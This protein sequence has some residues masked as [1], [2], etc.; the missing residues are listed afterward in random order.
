MQGRDYKSEPWN[1]NCVEREM[2]VQG[3]LVSDKMTGSCMKVLVMQKPF[4]SQS[5]KGSELKDQKTVCLKLRQGG[6][7]VTDNDKV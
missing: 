2:M 7:V 4:W 5:S 1:L 6:D 3:V